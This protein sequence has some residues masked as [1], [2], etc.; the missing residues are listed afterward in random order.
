MTDPKGSSLDIQFNSSNLQGEGLVFSSTQGKMCPQC[1]QPVNNCTCKQKPSV[2]SG[3]GVVRVSRETKGR[4]GKGVTV[5]TGIPLTGAPL[6]ALALK[7]KQRC[8]AGGTIKNGTLEIQGEH[9]DLLVAEL[10]KMG[11]NVKRT[12]G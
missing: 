12:G 9:R 6:K 5:V 8:G 2:P 7:L 1:S 4:K 10:A 11:Y 3:D